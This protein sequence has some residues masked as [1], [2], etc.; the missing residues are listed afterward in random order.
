MHLCFI[1][2]NQIM[3]Q[4]MYFAVI[5]AAI[6]LAGCSKY[7]GEYDI[8]SVYVSGEKST[9]QTGDKYSDYA[10]NPFVNTV[11][12]NISTFSVDADGASY[13]NMRRF[14]NEGSMPN[15]ASVR[16]EE[17]L[18]YFTFDYAEPTGNDNVAINSEIA[19]CPWNTEHRLL[20][21]GLKGKSL[22]ASELPASNYVFLID[23]SGSMDSPDKLELLKTGMSTMVDYLRP[24]DRISIITYA[25]TVQRLLESTL[26]SDAATIKKAIGKLIASGSTAGGAALEMAYKEAKDHYIK[27]GNN[28]IIL[29][30]DGDFNVGVT[31]TTALVE[32]VENYAK[33]GIYL[34]A[35][36]FGRGNLNDSMM[37]KI[38]DSGNGNYEYIDNE[39]QLTKVFVNEI[40]KFVAVANDTKIQ[41]TF[42]STVVKSYRLIG[43]E[44]RILSSEDF[45]NDKKDAGE[46][47]AG[48]TITALYEI[49][50]NKNYVT[51]SSCATFNVRY[52]KSL[53][54]ESIPLSTKI[55]CS[56]EAISSGNMSFASSLAAFGM[57]LRDSKYKGNATLDMVSE[58]ASKGLAFDPFG[59]RKQYV[60]LVKAAKSI[61]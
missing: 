26:A 3:K 39:E 18:N 60:E 57:I 47:G 7:D 21:L 43:Y 16:I 22:A 42:D 6:F 12:Q 61:K 34:T 24:T 31:S 44:N 41:I 25:G 10:D 54:S 30:T 27:G 52:K 33:E 37:E 46:I 29:G 56:N 23:V 11:K 17:F 20:R 40:S 53:D 14:I 4:K 51:G 19:V 48:Q 58:L 36:G 5:S 2:I 8:S 38:A 55:I 13:G 9:E 45:E 28:R 35:C 1:P 59:Y 15:A 50:P 49:I 32:M